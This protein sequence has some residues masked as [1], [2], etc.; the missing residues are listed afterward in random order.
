M[1]YQSLEDEAI[2]RLIALNHQ[3][4]LSVLYDRYGRL[5]YSVA[6]NIMGNQELA[7]EVTQEVFLRVWRRAST[8]RFGHSKVSTWLGSIT[9]HRAIDELRRLNVRPKLHEALWA[10]EGIL[11]EET[12]EDLD[13]ITERAIEARQVRAAIERLPKEQKKALA[14]AFFKGLTHS[15]IADLL[16]EPLGTV[17]TRI[18]L[19]MQKLR[20]DLLD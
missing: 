11:Q 18:R 5:V 20:K 9:R 14:L 19:A 15:E 17:K 16:G 12:G 13:A 4:A 6:R 2:L 1:D 10:D 7:E 8:Y 3:D